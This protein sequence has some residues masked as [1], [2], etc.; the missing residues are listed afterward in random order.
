MACVGVGSFVKGIEVSLG[1]Y[2]VLHNFLRILSILFS[3]LIK[4][5][6]E[7]YGTGMKLVGSIGVYMVWL[8]M[9]FTLFFLFE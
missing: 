1:C 4:P 5:L 2:A 3:M 8:N 7:L 6:R 9:Y